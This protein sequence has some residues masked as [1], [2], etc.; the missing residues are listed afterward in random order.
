MARK[1]KTAKKVSTETGLDY[2]FPACPSRL[3]K[4]GFYLY[5]EGKFVGYHNFCA[6]Y[7][8]KKFVEVCLQ[9]NKYEWVDKPPGYPG[10][11]SGECI[12]DETGLC[13]DGHRLEEVINYEYTPKEAE[14]E[15][16]FPDNKDAYYIRLRSVPIGGSFNPKGVVDGISWDPEENKG[17]STIGSYTR[18]NAEEKPKRE[19]KERKPKVSKDGLVS[20]GDIATEL[21]CEPGDA[22]A[23]LRKSKVEKPEAGWC[24]PK[25]QVE[26]IKA[27]IQKGL[28]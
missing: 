8:A 22:R 3:P 24:W 21:G 2:P 6:T 15:L 25:E 1:S 11:G 26:E 4:Y 23:V 10:T 9:G 5:Y 12:E 16:P 28:K 7:A 13:I 17:I 20:V 27:I 18:P 14:W 19:K